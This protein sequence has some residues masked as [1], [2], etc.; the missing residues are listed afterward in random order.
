M[1]RLG[2]S[3]KIASR[4]WERFFY[5]CLFFRDISILG[6]GF[7]VCDATALGGFFLSDFYVWI[8]VSIKV[9]YI[10]KY[11]NVLYVEILK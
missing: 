8:F 5:V 11:W 2:F 6:V 7:C 1:A 3:G 4:D 9:I 10:I